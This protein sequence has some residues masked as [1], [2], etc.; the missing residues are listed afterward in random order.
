MNILCL[1]DFLDNEN[2]LWEPFIFF[3]GQFFNSKNLN[4]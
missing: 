3:T 2:Y 1:E 4:S